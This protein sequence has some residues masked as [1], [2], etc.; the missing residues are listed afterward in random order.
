MPKILFIQ[1][2]QYRANK[3]E[4]C[5]QKKLYLPGLV[6]PLLAAMLPQNWE[7]QLILE[8]VD[9]VDYDSDADLIAIGS[10]G[11][12]MYRGIEIADEFRSKGKKVVM[13]GYMASIAKE[14]AL[15]HSDSIVIGDAEISFPKMIKDFEMG[16]LKK[17]YDYPIEN[18]ENLPI[19][20]YDLLINK[21]IGN[22]LPVQAGRGCTFH[23]SFCSIAC[24][25]KGKYLSR[26]INDVIRDIE[27]IK[28]LGYKRFYMIDDNIISNPRYLDEF[29]GK[30]TK[31]KMKWST[32]CSIHLAKDTKLLKKVVRAGGEIFSFGLESINQEGLENLNK[33]WLKVEDHEK[34]L[35]ILNNSGII[36]S[37][38]MII[39]TDGDT[40][41]SIIET[42]RFVER[43]KI[44]IPRFYI[45][46]PIPYT[47][48]YYQL[49]TE[50]RLLTEDWHLFDGTSAVMRPKL[51]EPNKLTD[52]YWWLYNEIFSLRSIASRLILNKT[53]WKKPF[54]LFFAIAVN[55]HYR[56]YV[57]K[58]LPP[59]IF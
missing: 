48:L 45:L 42:K 38:E 17:I 34:N 33:S 20:R 57:R 37:S 44:A 30:V 16:K 28:S 1:P 50:G 4:L 7:V 53:L 26:P 29:C 6:F 15:Q 35:K 24:I 12:A 49:R 21:P 39:G 19:P 32:Q 46:T 55:L 59:N 54:M 23:C 22:M 27:V 8:V 51:I 5:K 56:K 36:I 58:R 14:I 11:Y 52:M 31:Y 41:N 25:Y 10:M 13:G 3:M 43:N 2:T 40:V 47:E 9:E 18:L